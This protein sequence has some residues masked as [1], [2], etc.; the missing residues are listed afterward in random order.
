[1][2]MPASGT[3]RSGRNTGG[4]IG[5]ALPVCVIAGVA[6]V[7][8]GFDGLRQI[9]RIGY[10]RGVRRG[11]FALLGWPVLLLVSAIFWKAFQRWPAFSSFAGGGDGTG[12]ASRCFDLLLTGHAGRLRPLEERGMN[13]PGLEGYTLPV[14]AVAAC[15]LIWTGAGLLLWSGRCRTT[16]ARVLWIILMFA[17][18]GLVLWWAGTYH[19][20]A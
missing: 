1:M 2:R 16:P 9:R 11:V 12:W 8:L 14:M 15:L 10:L 13:P 17:A 3:S 7:M 6:G 20:A 4:V 18:G 5:M 19:F